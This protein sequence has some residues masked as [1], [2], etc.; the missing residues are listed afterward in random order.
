MSTLNFQITVSCT[1]VLCTNKFMTERFYNEHRPLHNNRIT[2]YHIIVVIR[3]LR[4]ATSIKI[5]LAGIVLNLYFGS[6]LNEHYES[7][8]MINKFLFPFEP[9]FHSLLCVFVCSVCAYVCMCVHVRTC[10]YVCGY[11]CV[12]GSVQYHV[13]KKLT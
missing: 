2:I 6:L 7:N 10:R 4:T 12:G 1:H 13:L 5:I 3:Q 9:Q 8:M 11:M